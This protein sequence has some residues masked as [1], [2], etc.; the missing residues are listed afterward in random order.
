LRS[1]V[2]DDP[3]P[4]SRSHILAARIIRRPP[5]SEKL[6]AL[7]KRLTY[8]VYV[9]G[10]AEG[11]RRD[12][13]TAAW[14]TQVAFNPLL[15]VLSVNRSNASFPLLR[16]AGRFSVSVL[17]QDQVELARHFGTKSG[18]EV[19]KLA[20]IDWRPGRFGAPLLTN[21]LAYL[22]CRVHGS[23][24]AGDHELILGLVVDGDVLDPAAE[25]LTYAETGDMDGSAALYPE[26][27]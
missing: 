8:G 16:F 15:V 14:F 11:A 27:F 25:P 5:L 2:A 26:R 10:V 9:I 3:P 7:F 22:E 19:D 13:F 24:P 20:G 18:R 6:S 1:R 12:A 21:A 23:M 17:K 4:D